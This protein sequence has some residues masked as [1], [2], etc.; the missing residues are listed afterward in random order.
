MGPLRLGDQ[1]GSEKSADHTEGLASLNDCF[2]AVGATVST[3]NI[4]A[5]SCH[6]TTS[7]PTSKLVGKL[8]LQIGVFSGVIN[9]T[10]AFVIRNMN[11]LHC[12]VESLR[13]RHWLA[14]KF[15]HRSE[16]IWEFTRLFGHFASH[17]VIAIPSLLYRNCRH[18]HR[19]F[20]RLWATRRQLR[21]S[22]HATPRPRHD[23]GP[24][25]MRDRR[26]GNPPVWRVRT[27]GV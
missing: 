11:S 14:P 8:I 4:G 6:Q 27:K 16:K 9:R 10:R 12:Q 23:D 17:T 1:K 19:T 21:S 18:K 5:Q 2:R 26:S 22:L 20:G 25:P 3:S 15:P 7:K 24:C 13:L